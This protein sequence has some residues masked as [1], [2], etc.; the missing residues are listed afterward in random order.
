MSPENIMV[1]KEA[2]HKRPHIVWFHLYEER[3]RSR[4]I[5]T[6]SRWMVDQS[7]WEREGQG[8]EVTAN[9]HGVSFWN[10]DSILKLEYSKFHNPV[11]ILNTIDLHTY[12]YLNR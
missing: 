10:D 4:S 7:L 2:S 5:T 9:G 8:W 6:E 1:S 3:T 11:N 12:V